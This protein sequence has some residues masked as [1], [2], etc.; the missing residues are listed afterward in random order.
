MHLNSISWIGPNK[1]YD[2][3]D[4]RFH[5]DNIIIDGRETNIIAIIDKKTG[6]IV[7][8]IGPDYT[9]TPALRKL[10]QIIGQHHAHIIPKGLPGAGNLLV[11]DNGGYAGYDAPTSQAP[12]GHPRER[13]DWSR[14]IELN[15]VTLEVVWQ[16]GGEKLGYFFRWDKHKFFSPYISSAQRLPNGNTLVTEGSEG[17]LFEAT[18][19]YEIV[20]EY[21]HPYYMK[22]PRSKKK[23]WNLVYRAYRVPYD[24]IPQLPKPNE[25]AITPPANWDFHVPGSTPVELDDAVRELKA[26]PG[27]H[28]P[29]PEKFKEEEGPDKLKQY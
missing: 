20:W 27:M 19:K 28:G 23:T 25:K 12:T 4:Q 14:V 7:W 5:P 3:G 13:R 24:W 2:Q 8:Q 17:R 16:R 29:K 15:P 11:F 6:K 10:R 26:Q 9:K 18:P 22:P 21:I 1:W